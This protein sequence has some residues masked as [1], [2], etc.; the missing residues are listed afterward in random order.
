MS[1]LFSGQE[2]SLE[3]NSF[4]TLP[5]GGTLWLHHDL[6]RLAIPVDTQPTGRTLPHP[7]RRFNFYNLQSIYLN[8]TSSQTLVH[9]ILYPSHTSKSQADDPAEQAL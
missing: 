5:S 9:S 8:R 3:I 4:S 2:T 7:I 6:H 1:S